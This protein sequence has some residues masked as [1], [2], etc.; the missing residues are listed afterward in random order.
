M[1]IFGANGPT[2][3]ILAKQALV[4]GHTVVAATRHPEAFPLQ[5]ARL[6][7]MSADVFDL[8]SVEQAVA[9]QEA[10]LLFLVSLIVVNLSRSIHKAQPISSRP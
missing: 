9:G 4:A 5:D 6:Q 8:A 3:H 1:V 7:L 2:G 10:I